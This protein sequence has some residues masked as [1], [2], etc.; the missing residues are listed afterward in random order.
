[1]QMCVVLFVEKDS[2]NQLNAALNYKTNG[3]T[4]IQ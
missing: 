3:R 4:V 2:E 1:M